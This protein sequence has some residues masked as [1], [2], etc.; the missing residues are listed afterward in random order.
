MLLVR[1]SFGARGRGVGV[2][3]VAATVDGGDGDVDELFGERIER[4][5]G[6]HDLLDARPGSFEKFGLIG[7]GSPE[8]VDEVGF[9]GGADVVEDCLEAWVSRDFGVGPE[10]YGGHMWQDL[11]ESF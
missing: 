10:F 1:H 9:S 11:S 6:D 5:W 3:A 2:D 4:A 8:V 7:Q